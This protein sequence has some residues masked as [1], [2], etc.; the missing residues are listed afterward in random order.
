VT[1]KDSIFDQHKPAWET[2]ICNRSRIRNYIQLLETA[3]LWEWAAVKKQQKDS[4]HKNRV[5]KKRMKN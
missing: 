2:G 5:V 1:F 4:L 3:L